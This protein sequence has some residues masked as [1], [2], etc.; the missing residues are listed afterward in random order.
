MSGCHSGPF[1]QL[2]RRPLLS[3]Q[4]QLLPGHPDAI[5]D[6]EPIIQIHENTASIS[7]QSRDPVT[8]S[9]EY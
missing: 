9:D 3:G 2:Q 1:G 6:E 8:T 5:S 7:S 4:W